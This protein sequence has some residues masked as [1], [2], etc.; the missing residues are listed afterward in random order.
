MK[1][2]PQRL[3]SD[4]RIGRIAKFLHKNE[5]SILAAWVQEQSRRFLQLLL[6]ATKQSLDPNSEA[7]TVLRDMISARPVVRKGDR[8]IE[9]SKRIV[10]ETFHNTPRNPG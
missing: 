8:F 1:A 6:H 3:V 9:E 7:F 4:F 10:E 5:A 2:K